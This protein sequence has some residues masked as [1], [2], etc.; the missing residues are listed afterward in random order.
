MGEAREAAAK[1]DPAQKSAVQLGRITTATEEDED[2]DVADDG[3]PAVEEDL[4]VRRELGDVVEFLAVGCIPRERVPGPDD[5]AVVVDD[6]GLDGNDGQQHRKGQ[7]EQAQEPRRGHAAAGAP[8]NVP[9][10]AAVS[11][12]ADQD[13]D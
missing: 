8:E 6:E 9:K 13:E 12:E 2:Q 11:M 5:L 1:A 7:Q 4:A 10:F 3:D